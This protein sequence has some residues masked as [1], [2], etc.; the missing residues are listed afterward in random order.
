MAISQQDPHPKKPHGQSVTCEN[1]EREVSAESLHCPYCCGQDGRLGAFRRGAFTG[2]VLGLM[3]GGVG[4]AVLLSFV[5]PEY[6]TWSV[7]S[8]VVLCFVFAGAV[9]GVMINRNE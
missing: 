7:V 4:T 9:L 1:C 5:G 8:G 2:G 3:A 6:N